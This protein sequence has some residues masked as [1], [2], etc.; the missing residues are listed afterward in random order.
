MEE[1]VVMPEDSTF[2]IHDVRLGAYALRL[3]SSKL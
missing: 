3:A 1:S 2:D